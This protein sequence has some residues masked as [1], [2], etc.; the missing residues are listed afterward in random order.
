MTKGCKKNVEKLSGSHL[1]ELKSV[2]N[3]HYVG[4]FPNQELPS[5]R[6]SHEELKCA[7]NELIM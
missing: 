5:L 4:P 6:T 3:C 7:L 2:Q 1:N